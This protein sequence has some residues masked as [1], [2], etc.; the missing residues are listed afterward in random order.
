ML[1]DGEFDN[2]NDCDSTM[3][4]DGDG[5]ASID[6]Q[7]FNTGLPTFPQPSMWGNVK[8]LTLHQ[9]NNVSLLH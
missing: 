6:E 4:N 5:Q 9:C 7:Y 8:E 1:V 3:C 2:S